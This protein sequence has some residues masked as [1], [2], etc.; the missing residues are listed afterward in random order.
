M[1]I[2]NSMDVLINLDGTIQALFLS[3]ISFSKTRQN[4]PASNRM[5]SDPTEHLKSILKDNL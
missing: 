5:T 2:I 4:I 1:W 3:T